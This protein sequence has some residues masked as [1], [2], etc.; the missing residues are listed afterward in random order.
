MKCPYC[1]YNS[2]DH[3]EYCKKC[4]SPLTAGPEE[5]VSPDENTGGD[6]E[7]SRTRPESESAGSTGELFG[8]GDMPGGGTA[9]ARRYYR[10]KVSGRKRKSRAKNTPEGESYGQLPDSKDVGSRVPSRHGRHAQDRM[11]NPGSQDPSMF[12]EREYPP[13]EEDVEK[14]ADTYE[15]EPD[16]YNLAGVFSRA[17]AIIVDFLLVSLI[18]FLAATAALY[19][20]GGFTLEGLGSQDLF[21][22]MYIVLFFLASSYFVFL[23]GYG[24]KTVGKIL[25]GIRLINYEG[26]RVGF[27]SAFVRWLGY[28]I[29]AAF[30]FAG[31][32][33]ALVD[34]EYQTWHDKAAGTYVVKD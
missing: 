15:P 31:F 27:G 22:P 19:L 16:V 14:Y 11:R 17:I 32:L 5:I 24:G 4:G 12:S 28:Y 2:F 20:V 33:W 9:S 26:E 30:L 34:S 10:S 25:M 8:E 13:T 23:H 7:S 29:S 1:G 3:L 6:E 18:A 21:V